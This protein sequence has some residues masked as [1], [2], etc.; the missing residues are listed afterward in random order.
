[1]GYKTTIAG[2]FEIALSNF[3]GLFVDQGIYLED[4]LLNII[5]D[6]KGGSYSFTTE[7]GTFNDRF[8]LRYTDG[9]ALANN[10]LTA[11]ENKVVV[12]KN[13]SG[14][15]INSSNMIMSSVRVLDIRGRLV[16]QKNNINGTTTVLSNLNIQE[17]VLVIQVTLEDGQIINKKIIF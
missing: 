16:H 3:D 5:H 4:K 1:M 14:I 10:D 9:V 7:A 2:S 8:L 13:D 12:F 17:G 6:L 15:N 11:S